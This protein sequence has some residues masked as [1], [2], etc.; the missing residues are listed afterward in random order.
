MVCVCYTVD[1]KKIAPS[2]V[3]IILFLFNGSIYCAI[4]SF[5]LLD[6]IELYFKDTN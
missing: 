5:N 4:N 3:K 1:K 6:V 2:V